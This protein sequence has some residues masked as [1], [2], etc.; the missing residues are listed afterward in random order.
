[1]AYIDCTFLHVLTPVSIENYGFLNFFLNV[2]LFV[3][4][5]KFQYNVFDDV[6]CSICLFKEMLLL[7]KTLLSTLEF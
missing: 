2:D 3:F 7:P 5:L 6:Y 4:I 1:M